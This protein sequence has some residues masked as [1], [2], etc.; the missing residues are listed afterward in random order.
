MLNY[1]H[2]THALAHLNLSVS[3]L[4]CIIQRTCG[5]Q[6]THGTTFRVLKVTSQVTMPGAESAVYDWLVAVVAGEL[7]VQSRLPVSAA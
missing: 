6:R 7:H 1:K 4:K 5:G 2:E 3:R